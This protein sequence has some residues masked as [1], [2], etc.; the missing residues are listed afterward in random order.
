MISNVFSAN[1]K[2]LLLIAGI[3][4]STLASG[5]FFQQQGY[6][7][8]TFF[9]I[10]VIFICVWQ[11][12]KVSR[13]FDRLAFDAMKSLLNNDYSTQVFNSNNR[14]ISESW[15]QLIND[16]FIHVGELVHQQKVTQNYWQVLLAQVPVVLFSIKEN[17]EVSLL[18]LAAR[19]L[20]SQQAP[21]T[22]AD[23]TQ[24]K[25]NFFQQLQT[26]KPGQSVLIQGEI[27]NVSYSFYASTTFIKTKINNKE[28]SERLVSLL[29]IK[30]QL[31]I[32]QVTAWQDLVHVL[33]HEIMNSIAPIS[34][35]SHSLVGIS[36]QSALPA[37]ANKDLAIGL[38]AIAK[39]S[40]RLI[41]FITRYKQ[42]SQ[43]PSP[44]K[45]PIDLVSFI[46][47]VI[48]YTKSTQEQYLDWQVDLPETKII[49]AADV[50]L[51]EQAMINILKNALQAVSEKHS[52]GNVDSNIDSN[53]AADNKGDKALIK[54]VCR[55][56]N[57]SKVTID[58]I[59]NGHGI[60][61]DKL[62]L[63]FMPFYSTRSE[64]KGIGL[65]LSRQIILAHNATISAMN[66]KLTGAT[67]RMTFL[68][69]ND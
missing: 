22:L 58:I 13:Q 46:K 12:I 45:V 64:G 50:V 38:S 53:V 19:N 21:S 9:F 15:Q 17:D 26:I 4:I 6:Q 55:N 67:I 60:A 69:E 62:E 24:F 44:K 36:Q 65:S 54:V 47:Q 3:I 28:Q 1:F 31:D 18:N 33:T 57:K 35:L 52:V 66:N 40:D 37:E 59:D 29:N 10:G 32:A 56:D 14:A 2:L 49:I 25:G 41:E 61:T 34:S 30:T 42:I 51:L 43:V 5:Y 39:R 7:A 23:F 11:L 63:I 8:T 48:N 20:F 16:V 27:D 68:Q